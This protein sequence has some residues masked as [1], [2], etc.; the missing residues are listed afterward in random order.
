MVHTRSMRYWWAS[1]GKNYQHVAHKGNLW[2]CPRAGGAPLR[3]RRFIQELSPGDVV[4]H[5]GQGALRALSEVTASA[6]PCPRPEHYPPDAGE[7]D[8]GWLV[9]SD[10]FLPHLQVSSVEI[11]SVLPHGG[12]SPL[13]VNGI[14]KT[15]FLHE[16]RPAYA[17]ALLHLVGVDEPPA[18]GREEGD[19]DPVWAGA[20]TSVVREALARREQAALRELLLD[21]RKVASCDLCGRELPAE[22]LVAAHIVPRHRLTDDERRDLGRIAMLACSL[23]CDALFERGYI[24]VDSSGTVQALSD[25]KNAELSEFV[26]AIDGRRCTA[27]APATARRFAD[28]YSR[29]SRRRQDGSVRLW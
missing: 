18:E 14:A 24:A 22:L 15:L 23:G 6:V 27:H 16:L 13:D 26:Q 2:T 28:H 19:G 8:D 17:A 9:E 1:Q 3:S 12:D 20:H 7:G 5:Y 25:A 21:D 11:A 10:P 4:F 29:A